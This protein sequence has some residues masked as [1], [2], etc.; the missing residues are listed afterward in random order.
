MSILAPHHLIAHPT[1]VSVRPRHHE[2]T[3]SF[4]I[5]LAT[6]NRCQP[7]SFL[8]LLGTLP[9]GRRSALTPGCTVSMN[10]A[11]LTRLATYSGRQ[12]EALIRSFPSI[13]APERWLEPTVL[14][15]HGQQTFLR[16]CRGC[17]Q[18][19]AGARLMSDQCRLELA[20]Q[21]HSVWL[22]AAEPADLH[23]S[24]ETFTAFKRLV[25]LRPRHGD[26]VVLDLYNQL[27]EYLTNDWRGFGWHNILVRRWTN[28]HRAVFGAGR[29]TDEFVRT[30]T[31]HWSMLP[32]TVALLARFADPPGS[33]LL[34]RQSSHN[35]QLLHDEIKRMLS[36][37]DHTLTST[38]PLNRHGFG[39]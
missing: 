20:C 37:D 13:T 29:D 34:Q 7:W 26:D 30:R 15:H 9:G 32:E 23:Q 3:G 28:R 16:A 12:E 2:G 31:H 18:R 38:T 24:P 39:L 4:L 35:H 33:R 36:I 19:A 6:A 5:R 22:V 10:G 21:R 25:R 8:R 27:H 14:I 17:E 1:P 11:A